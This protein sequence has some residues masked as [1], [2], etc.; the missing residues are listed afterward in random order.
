ML[1]AAVWVSGQRLASCGAVGFP[2]RSLP[3]SSLPQEVAR[4][5][6]SRFTVGGGVG[7]GARLRRG[8]PRGTVPLPSPRAHRLGRRG[9]AVTCVVAC[10]GAGSAALVGSAGG[11][12]SG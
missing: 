6:L 10:V 4:A 3:P 11:S 8:G 1:G 9:A 12:A 5:P 2:S 7:R